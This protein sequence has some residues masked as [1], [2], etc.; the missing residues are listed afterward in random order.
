MAVTIG[1]SCLVCHGVL[2]ILLD[3]LQINQ[4]FIVGDLLR[5]LLP[6]GRLAL[7]F[8]LLFGG[9]NHDRLDGLFFRVCCFLLR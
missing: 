8:P 2:V 5:C 3:E 6:G 4:L 1:I 9:L 7:T